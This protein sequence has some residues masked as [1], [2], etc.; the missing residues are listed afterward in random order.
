MLE[1]RVS[2]SNLLIKILRKLPLKYEERQPLADT[3]LTRCNSLRYAW[4]PSCCRAEAYA[5]LIGD[6]PPS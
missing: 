6:A 3:A 1:S 4:L 5:N 2:L